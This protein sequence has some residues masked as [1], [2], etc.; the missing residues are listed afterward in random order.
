[1]V[2]ILKAN[3]VNL[4]V[5]SVLFVL[6]YH[7]PNILDTPHICNI[8]W[9]SVKQI[10]YAFAF[11]VSKSVRTIGRSIRVSTIVHSRLLI[12]RVPTFRQRCSFFWNMTLRHR[13]LRSHRSFEET[14]CF[15]TNSRQQTN[16]THKP[17]P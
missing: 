7:S 1:M 8:S 2:I 13:V 14:C 9:L 12:F 6:W 4:F 17:F 15:L 16:K 10:P 5:S 3:K 11:L